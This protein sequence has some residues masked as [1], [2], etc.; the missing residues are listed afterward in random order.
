MKIMEW[1][2]SKTKPM[3]RVERLVLNAL[4][5]VQS[6]SKA[7]ITSALEALAPL[8]T[9]DVFA[10]LFLRTQELTSGIDEETLLEAVEL[11]LPPNPTEILHAIH[12]TDIRGLQVA[13]G[14]ESLMKIFASLLVLIAALKD[15]RTR[16]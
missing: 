13:V 12:A 1:L 9:G 2:Q 14:S 8:E 7:E 10:E 15:A 16:L 6:G 11:P 5:A 3:D 4:D